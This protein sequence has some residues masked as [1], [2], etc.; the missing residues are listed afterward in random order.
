MTEKRANVG[1]PRRIKPAPEKYAAGVL[2]LLGL[3][4][5]KVAPDPN[6]LSLLVNRR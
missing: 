1:R 2:F 3:Q 6:V 4:Y 5:R